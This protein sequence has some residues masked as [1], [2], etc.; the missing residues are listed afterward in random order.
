M[1]TWSF[2]RWV[3]DNNVSTSFEYGK[4]W[5]DYVEL[6]R[7]FAHYLDAVEVRVVG[8]YHIDTPPPCERL[9]MPAVAIDVAGVTFALRHDFG[10][11]SLRHDLREWAVSVERRSPYCGPLFGLIRETED[12]RDA[13]LD[14]L[15]PNYVFGSYR[16]DPA[17]FT[18]LL[19]DEWDVAAAMR[20]LA[21][22]P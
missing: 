21:H 9:P 7:R 18:T 22:E 6:I 20:I 17:Q 16:E 5:W 12:L 1:K 15:A 11:R 19:R 13:G 2:D 3:N 10:A 4:G 14:G 8:H